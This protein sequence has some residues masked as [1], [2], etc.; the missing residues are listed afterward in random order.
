MTVSTLY[1]CHRV[2]IFVTLSISLVSRI[3]G[4]SKPYVEI[5]TNLFLLN[6]FL[7]RTIIC[8]FGKCE[9]V[10]PQNSWVCSNVFL[11]DLCLLSTNLKVLSGA[12]E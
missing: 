11:R 7:N 10:Y 5:I 8:L 3:W 6:L 2:E 9:A 12:N 1:N 4:P